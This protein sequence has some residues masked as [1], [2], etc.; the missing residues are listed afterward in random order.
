ME[1]ETKLNKVFNQLVDILEKEGVY[2]SVRSTSLG[3]RIVLVDE[4]KADTLL[5]YEGKR[6]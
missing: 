5:W 2:L 6:N 4:E 3:H 1:K